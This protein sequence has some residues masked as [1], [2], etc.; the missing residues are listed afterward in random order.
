[1]LDNPEIAKQNHPS[2]ATM[3]KE[4]LV[5]Q[6]DEVHDYKD[7]DIGFCEVCGLEQ[8]YGKHT[9]ETYAAKH[10]QNAEMQPQTM[11]SNKQETA[12]TGCKREKLYGPRYDLMMRNEPGIRRLA[13]TWSEGNEKYGPD[14]WMK[15]FPISVAL[16]HALD[17]IAKYLSGDRSEDHLAHGA[18]NLLHACYI[19]EKKPELCDLTM[20]KEDPEDAYLRA[21]AKLERT[22]GP[23]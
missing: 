21:F 20:P 23:Q 5:N 3:T 15:G 7:T 2:V 4:T 1:M 14:N 22:T 9:S 18:W 8:G 6:G 13:E 12:S 16:N 11:L 10:N 17:H 19:E